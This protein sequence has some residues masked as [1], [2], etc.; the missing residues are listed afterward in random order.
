MKHQHTDMLAQSVAGFLE[1]RFGRNFLGSRKNSRVVNNLPKQI[2]N[3]CTC[4]I[5]NRERR[6]RYLAQPRQREQYEVET[7][8]AETKRERVRIRGIVTIRFPPGSSNLL[9]KIYLRASILRIFEKFLSSSMAVLL[10]ELVD[11]TKD[12]DSHSSIRLTES[13]IKRSRDFSDFL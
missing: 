12:T 2:N 6:S 5:V 3:L 13:T 4:P 7:F 1:F 11:A 9:P 8:V 10:R